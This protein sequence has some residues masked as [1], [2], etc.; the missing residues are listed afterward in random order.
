M[1]MIEEI[2][3]S[4]GLDKPM[5]AWRCDDCERPKISEETQDKLPSCLRFICGKCEHPVWGG[6]GK[7]IIEEE[8]KAE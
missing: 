8:E 1:T 4:I 2:F 5:P 3:K 6:Y 7:V